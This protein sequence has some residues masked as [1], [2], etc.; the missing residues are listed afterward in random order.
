MNGFAYFGCRVPVTRQSR[1][2]VAPVGD[3]P[4]NK[5][6]LKTQ[7]LRVPLILWL[8]S[9][10]TS[11]DAAPRVGVLVGGAPQELERFAADQLCDYLLKLFGVQSFPSRHFSRDVKGYFLVGNPESNANVKR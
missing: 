11:V 7:A 5:S 9:L 4:Y 8:L 1:T 10:A 6:P 3:R 2:V